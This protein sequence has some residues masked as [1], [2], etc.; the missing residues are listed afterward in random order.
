MASTPVGI[1]RNTRSKAKLLQTT[2]SVHTTTNDCNS[3][4]SKLKPTVRNVRNL[5]AL[6]TH[7]SK[8]LGISKNSA[9]AQLSTPQVD[10]VKN[11]S[12]SDVKYASRIC[13]SPTHTVGDTT[14]SHKTSDTA[15][16]FKDNDE[17]EDRDASN[18]DA[19]SDAH[20]SSSS[21]SS[22][23]S[24]SS[25][26]DERTCRVPR[27]VLAAAKNKIQ[28][29]EAELAQYKRLHFL[30]KADTL[31]TQ[32]VDLCAYDIDMNV[33]DVPFAPA[34]RGALD[35]PGDDRN[36]YVPS[37]SSEASDDSEHDSTSSHDEESSDVDHDASV[38]ART[39]ERRR[40]QKFLTIR[41]KVRMALG[42]KLYHFQGLDVTLSQENAPLN[43]AVWTELQAMEISYAEFAACMELQW[44]VAT[45][46]IGPKRTDGSPV[47][48]IQAEVAGNNANLPD[49]A[50]LNRRVSTRLISHPVV[51]SHS[52]ALPLPEKVAECIEENNT[53]CT[54]LKESDHAIEII[55]PPIVVVSITLN[56]DA[57]TMNAPVNSSVTQKITAVEDTPQREATEEAGKGEEGEEECKSSA[58]SPPLAGKSKEEDNMS[59]DSP[60]YCDEDTSPQEW[61]M[62]ALSQT[63]V[64]FRRIFE[65][66]DVVAYEG[67]TRSDKKHVVMKVCDINTKG[68]IPREVRLLHRA[69]SHPNICTLHAWHV[70]TKT[71]S[72]ALVTDFVRN[73]G[74]PEDAFVHDHA[75]QKKYMSDILAG[76]QH[77]HKQGILYR[78]IKPS[79]VLWN[80]QDN[81]A[82]IIDFDIATL[83]QKNRLHRSIVGTDGYMAP[84][85]LLIKFAKRKHLKLPYLGYGERVDV[86]GAGILLGQLLF[87][88]SEKQ[89][90]DDDNLFC[91]GPAFLR[92]TAVLAAKGQCTRAHWLL[93]RMLHPLPSKR[94]SIEEILSDEWFTHVGAA[95]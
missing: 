59:D 10:L 51:V 66:Q 12:H 35:C 79:N 32:G 61:N 69:Q 63:Y 16:S 70:F 37:S 67:I 29:L 15:T 81:C 75:I 72:Y 68:K 94:A 8:E 34:F 31:K 43:A 26:D 27:A 21:S 42:R 47:H 93:V 7:S 9:S 20:H 19:D 89:V 33:A 76:I 80:D 2:M 77:L 3:A 78:D 14:S 5:K 40:H 86:Y 88:C 62:F 24:S 50:S 25:S 84:E 11:A 90:M 38:A 91:K 1:S 85:V 28:F 48:A 44:G 46:V 64:L 87:D 58:N 13:Q 60:T 30:S 49:T 71:N 95:V 52:A 18:S 4:D 45:P 22:S 73:R 57:V 55:Q 36:T 83:Y 74:I 56:P 17:K 6:R 82:K 54:E 65:G 92:K 23:R 53:T 41:K 39:M